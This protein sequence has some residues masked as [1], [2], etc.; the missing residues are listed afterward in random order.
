MAW[1]CVNRIYHL[2]GVLDALLREGHVLQGG[3]VVEV[4]AHLV[5][6][7]FASLEQLHQP[8]LQEGLLVAAAAP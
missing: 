8:L 5:A 2:H 1:A 6:H 7:H 4:G 3:L